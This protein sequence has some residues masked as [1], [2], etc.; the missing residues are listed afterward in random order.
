MNETHANIEQVRKWE[1]LDS[2][3]YVQ[4]HAQ[5][6][7]HANGSKGGR[8]FWRKRLEDETHRGGGGSTVS[9]KPEEPPTKNES[10]RVS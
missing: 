3:I 8:R 4:S 6:I 2:R 10:R 9:S 5:C 7:Y 1:H